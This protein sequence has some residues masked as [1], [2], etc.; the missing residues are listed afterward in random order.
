MSSVLKKEETKLREE[1]NFSNNANSQLSQIEEDER[2]Y[3]E[4]IVQAINN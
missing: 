2:L 4:A 1:F 3:D